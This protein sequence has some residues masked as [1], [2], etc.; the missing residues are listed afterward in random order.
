MQNPVSVELLEKA[1]KQIFD[2]YD[3]NQD[4]YLEKRQVYTLISHTLKSLGKQ[5]DAN[6]RQV[7]EFISAIDKNGDGKIERS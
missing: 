7:S 3:T 5:R 2:A 6:D 1:T 4:G